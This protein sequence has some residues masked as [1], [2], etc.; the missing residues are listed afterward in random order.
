MRYVDS[1]LGK[2]HSQRE[3]LE[4]RLSEANEVLTLR[5]SRQAENEEAMYLAKIADRFPARNATVSSLEYASQE[6]A[7]LRDNLE[8]LEKAQARKR[9]HA[10]LLCHA[11]EELRQDLEGDIGQSM[12]VSSSISDISMT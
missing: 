12:D 2:L 9:T 3:E 1:V 4:R 10:K 7:D 8:D 6:I 5:Q 11:V